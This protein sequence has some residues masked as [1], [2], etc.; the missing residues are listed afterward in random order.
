[1]KRW[2]ETRL[3]EPP[4]HTVSGRTGGSVMF[5]GYSRL[6]DQWWLVANGSAEKIAEPPE[7]FL[8]DD[9]ISNNLLTTPRARAETTPR[10]RRGKQAQQLV[11]EL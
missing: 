5:V 7:L 1:M 2:I 8:D 10:L 11:L 9:W 6:T 4:T 3:V